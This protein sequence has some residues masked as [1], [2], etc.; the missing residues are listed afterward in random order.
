L[1]ACVPRQEIGSARN[2]VA[3]RA[4]RSLRRK[5]ADGDQH[6]LLVFFGPEP[7]DMLRRARTFGIATPL[8]CAAVCHL[9]AYAVQRAI[10]AAPNNR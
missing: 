10:S 4:Y 1:V 8:L 9:E 6:P 3:S 5:K 2:S 7:G